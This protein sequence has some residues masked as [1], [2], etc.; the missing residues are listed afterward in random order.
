MLFFAPPEKQKALRTRLC[1][2]LRIP[3]SFSNKGSDVVF[4]A[5]G[6]GD[7]RIMRGEC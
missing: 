1:K 5:G 3:F 6:T 7:P 2:R 4:E